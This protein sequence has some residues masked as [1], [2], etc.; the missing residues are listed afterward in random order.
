MGL[1]TTLGTTLWM[2]AVVGAGSLALLVFPIVLAQRVDL[3]GKDF[4]DT[5]AS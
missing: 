4:N 2:H 3:S 1:W 5:D